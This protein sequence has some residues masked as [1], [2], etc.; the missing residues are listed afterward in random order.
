MLAGLVT[1]MLSLEK[2]NAHET[3]S[4]LPCVPQCIPTHIH[5]LD[6]NLNTHR[7]NK[8]R[9]EGHLHPKPGD[10]A[11][12]GWINLAPLVPGTG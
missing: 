8:R 6:E 9:L 12:L 3:T 11:G 7:Q 4:G 2:R 5:T 10:Q 1:Q